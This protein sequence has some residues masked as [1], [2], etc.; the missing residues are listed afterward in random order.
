[1]KV[2]LPVV[3]AIAASLVKAA[4]KRVLK[5]QLVKKVGEKILKFK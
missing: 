2:I 5:I 1:V 4:E 3:I